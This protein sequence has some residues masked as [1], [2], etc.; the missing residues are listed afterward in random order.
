MCPGEIYLANDLSVNELSGQSES[1]SI[2]G[3]QT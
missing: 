2:S 3:A 1:S